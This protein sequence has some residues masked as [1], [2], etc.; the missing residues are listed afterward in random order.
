MGD[1]HRINV[2]K[3]AADGTNW[4]V[5]RDRMAWAMESR[6][7]AD[8]LT[9]QT[10]PQAY[11]TAGVVNGLDAPT[12]WALGEAAVKQAIAASV[13]DSV[14]MR[15]RGGT[16]A[17]DVW[18]ELRALFEGRT[19]MIV[20][21]LRRQLQNLKCGDK[22]N[23]RTHFDNIA[24][25]REQ[26]AAMGTTI[27]DNEYT[28]ILL[29]S[30]PSTYDHNTSAMA[31]TT[32]LTNAAL[33]PNMVIRLIT[34]EY[35]RR[36]LKKPKDGQDEALGADAGKK[37][38]KAKKDVE[39][40]N[41]KKRGHM[42]PD[43]WAKGGGKEGQGPK[44]K[45]QEGAASADQQPEPD[46]EA[47]AAIE[48]VPEEEEIDQQ[49]FESTTRTESELY[50]SGASCHMSPFRQQFVSYRAI[51]PRPIMAANKRVFYASGIG[52]VRIRVP[53]GQISTPV[54]LRDTLYAPDIALTVVSIS[55][56]T[57]AGFTVSFEGKTCKIT[58]P[59]GK[60]IGRIP[61]NGNGLY[62]V[63]HM[64]AAG[65]TD[66]VID[67]RALH[68]RMGHVAADT[69]RALVRTQAISGIS[70]ID[71]GQ[72]IYCES[73]E[74]AKA[75]RKAIKK[76]REA[77][78]AKT[79]GEEVHSDVWGPSPLKTIGGRLYYVTFTDDFSRY[80]QI[81]LL[82][83]KDET[84]QAYKDFSAWVLTQHGT[85]IK[86]LRSDRGGEFT[87]GE[88]DRYL[89]EQGTERR[90]T[91]H[92]TPQHNGVAESLN[93]RLLER[94]RAILHQ[95][96]LPKHLWGE[97]VYFVTWLKNRTSTEALGNVTPYERLY[98][99]KPNLA[100]V[101]EWG[102]R[103]WVHT[104]TGSK[105][106][107]RAVEGH[108]VGYDKDSTHAH[109]IY[110]AGK[111]SISVERNVRFAP[112][113]ITIDT[114]PIPTNATRTVI[115]APP[116]Q[117]P[118]PPR[119]P[120]A[121]PPIL[122]M[123]QPSRS[124]DPDLEGEEGE[125]EEGEGE[126]DSRDPA[127]PGQYK[128]PAT[129]K[130]K[131]RSSAGEPSY[132]QP[133][134]TSTRK[135][136]PSE[137][138]RQIEAGEGTV[139]GRP[140]N[141][142]KGKGGKKSKKGNANAAFI[143]NFADFG[144]DCAFIAGL[145]PF[146]AAAIGDAH[147]DPTTV[148]EAQSRS[149]W[150][151][152]QQAMDREM[153]T[154]EDAGTW[155]TVLRPTGRNIVGSKWVFRIKRKSDGSIDK[156]KARLVAQGFTQIHGTDYF[157]TYSPVA[158]LTSFR[159]ILALAARED[160]DIDCFDFNGAYLNGELSKEED[161]YMKNPPGYD[162]D[163]DTVKHLKKSLYGLKQ[164][165]RKW[166][167]T[168]KRTLADLGF[169]VSSA[170][171]GVFHAYVDNHRTIIAVHVDDCAIT[172]SSGEQMQDFKKKIN[173]RHSITDLGP[174]HW[175]LGIKVTRDRNARTISLSQESYINTI[176]KRFNLDNAKP[177]PS[178]IIPGIS[179][180]TNDGPADETE[181]ARMAKTPYREAIGSLMY[182]S[183][184]TRPDISFAVSTLSQFLENPGEMHWEAVKRV[185]RYL[186][187]TKGHTLTYGGE[188]HE[189]TGY[190]DADGSGQDHRRA[191][192]GFAYLID[193]GAISW[194]S[195]K[196]ELVALSTAEAEYVAATHA[197]KEGIWLRRL[198]GELYD[199]V[200]PATTL[201]C[202]NQAALTLAT[203][204]NF[205]ARTKHID[206]RYHFIRYS[207]EI[208]AFKLIYCPTND[209]VADILT[210]ALPGWKVKGHTAALGLR[211]ACGG[212]QECAVNPTA[213]DR[214]EDPAQEPPRVSARWERES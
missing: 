87:S 66:E 12:R 50:D 119:P 149:D 161:I 191:I 115:T 88:F 3:L 110:W 105:L 148:K 5:Y 195:R 209:M 69:I 169:S 40:F 68:R 204:D 70:L 25:L 127:P 187:G 90:L 6:A 21:D 197:A 124:D 100:G 44:K 39:C 133:T 93:R 157:E 23:V 67:I 151:L 175:L 51:P 144:V 190:T 198:I 136:K 41:C 174:I 158:K 61:A 208:G 120:L 201:Y 43:C 86:K 26:L 49:V 89:K 134:R 95:S 111:N 118:P 62:R 167:D 22:D 34:D 8:H 78:P 60:T 137:R 153:K 24:N 109:R 94:V 140:M 138:V 205:H 37:T 46:I 155:E 36:T 135:S 30:I 132:A 10:M 1:E 98:G 7:L 147:D 131:A 202:D 200:I 194:R 91:T 32:A 33:T 45:G 154:L 183:V 84:F 129:S 2:P 159:A 96:S 54:V 128:S 123:T 9:N 11:A 63:E 16:R 73:C 192:S 17:M 122:P 116:A 182:A 83:S 184:A 143:E 160:W 65:V 165:G 172:S 56:I 150:P 99:K 31:T 85:K 103:V 80:T 20:V 18:D 179:Y 185:F 173:E 28:S 71:D 139:D 57:K 113:N 81:K 77:A 193:G 199:I 29:S 212:V 207:V 42:K 112:T 4:V 213:W 211:S 166:Y 72:P 75:T 203:T 188:R 181:A 58:S 171:P 177:I 92:D 52:D 126:E 79:F 206:I 38:K 117:P 14:F 13:P 19:Q 15:I 130:A 59:G 178:P 152:W 164:A 27:P 145:T 97:A 64:C 168:L 55:R 104:D 146:V 162:E 121:L 107:A 114:P 186:T 48:D 156:Y 210:K 76:E 125:E 102:Q 189:L 47:W 180:S 53:N 170:D 35:D 214:A 82:R 142:P 74:Y 108:W 163:N 101:P 106:D 176:V 196:Q 141:S